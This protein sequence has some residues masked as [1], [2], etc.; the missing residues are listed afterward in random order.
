M[1]SKG[2]KIMEIT[3]KVVGLRIYPS[4]NRHVTLEWESPNPYGPLLTVNQTMDIYDNN[5]IF[6]LNDTV[7]INI[8]VAIK[9]G[10][11]L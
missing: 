10:A 7:V 3:A 1:Y 4:G 8:K 6:N 11:Q 5:K 2:A 9:E